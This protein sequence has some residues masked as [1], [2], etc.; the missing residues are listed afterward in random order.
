MFL[1]LA[2]LV[3]FSY[4][5]EMEDIP[6]TIEVLQKRADFKIALRYVLQ[7]EGFWVNNSVDWGQET[8]AGISRRY[9]PDNKIWGVVDEYKKHHLLKWNDS[10]PGTNWYVNMHYVDLFVDNKF[11]DIKDQDIC[12]QTFDCYINSNY[13]GILIIN[14]TL[15]KMGYDVPI[16]G[17]M[18][19]NTIKALNSCN[20]WE[21]LAKFTSER[22]IFYS[23]LVIKQPSQL[24]FLGNWMSRVRI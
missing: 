16:I 21:F 6:K 10:I 23:E 22:A 20:K 5:M 4:P 13:R 18:R 14:R 1:L 3:S 7:R 15:S 9:C 12:N 17:E 24:I 11:F 2:F 8:Y 19:P